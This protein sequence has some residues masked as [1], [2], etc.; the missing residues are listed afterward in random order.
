M[1][2]KSYKNASKLITSKKKGTAKIYNYIRIE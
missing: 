2:V 1:L